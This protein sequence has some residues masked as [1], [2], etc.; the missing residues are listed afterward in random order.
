MLP[1]KMGP[2]RALPCPNKS[3]KKMPMLTCEYGA[4]RGLSVSRSRGRP[5]R[6]SR[7]QCA[8]FA[9]TTSFPSTT[10]AQ[11]SCG[12]AARRCSKRGPV[13]VVEVHAS[14]VVV[15]KFF[16]TFSVSQGAK[17]QDAEAGAR[18]EGQGDR[19]VFPR[20]AVRGK[21]WVGG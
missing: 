15:P 21:D 4:G 20:G 8:R 11:A 1:K 19:K 17:A 9:T 12:D 3:Q 14:G 5:G 7:G 10:G 13:Q 16:D 6:S 2:S 18:P